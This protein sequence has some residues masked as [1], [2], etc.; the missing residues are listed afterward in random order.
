MIAYALN[1]FQNE[2]E[3]HTASAIARIFHYEGYE[4]TGHSI[5]HLI[6]IIFAVYNILCK[7][8]IFLHIGI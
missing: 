4:L 2:M 1:I 5:I 3:M 8:H 6:Y 7:R